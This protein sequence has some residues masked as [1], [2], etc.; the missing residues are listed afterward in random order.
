MR[1]SL[2]LVGTVWDQEKIVNFSKIY[3]LADL[4]TDYEIK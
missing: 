1:E 3:N 2:I 4:K